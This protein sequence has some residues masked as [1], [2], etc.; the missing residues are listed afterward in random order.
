MNWKKRFNITKT[1]S[2]AFHVDTVENP[3]SSLSILSCL[4]L[5]T[6]ASFALKDLHA[7]ASA[8]ALTDVAKAIDDAHGGGTVAWQQCRNGTDGYGRHNLHRHSLL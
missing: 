4:P 7:L 5:R 2:Y 6:F 1:V 3:E 8:V